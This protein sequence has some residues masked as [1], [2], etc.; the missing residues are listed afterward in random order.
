MYRIEISS[1]EKYIDTFRYQQKI[2]RYDIISIYRPTL[3]FVCQI[4]ARSKPH[5]KKKLPRSAGLKKKISV[6]QLLLNP[7][8]GLQN[9]LTREPYRNTHGMAYYFQEFCNRRDCT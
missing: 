2:K 8:P 4:F 9:L 6:V 3:C 1:F 5:P 7:W